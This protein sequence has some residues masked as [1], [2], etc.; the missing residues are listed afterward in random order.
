MYVDQAH[1]TH[2]VATVYCFV[3][4]QGSYNIEPIAL[5]ALNKE[6]AL[7][8]LTTYSFV[9]KLNWPAAAATAT[10]SSVFGYI[11]TKLLTG[12]WKFSI[13]E[14]VR[15]A[16]SMA[17]LADNWHTYICLNFPG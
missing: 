5:N 9:F 3:L 7:D 2:V 1:I 11:G 12:N 14:H 6:I 13:S 8:N 4:L 15:K 10:V 17:A 16:I